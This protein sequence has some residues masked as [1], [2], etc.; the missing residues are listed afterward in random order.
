M[1]AHLFSPCFKPISNDPKADFPL[2]YCNK[3]SLDKESCNNFTTISIINDNE[4]LETIEEESLMIP[5]LPT[6]EIM[7]DIRGQIPNNYKNNESFTTASSS[8]DFDVSQ[9]NIVL[10]QLEVIS[11]P[12][13]QSIEEISWNTE[14]TPTMMDDIPAPK[15]KIHEN[16]MTE[17]K[18][19]TAT[20]DK[21]LTSVAVPTKTE[22]NNRD[23]Q[24]SQR[25]KC[26]CQKSKC[27][28]LYCECFYSGNFC[29]DCNCD[30]C[31][32]KS[33]FEAERKKASERIAAKN[34]IGYN[35]R[36]AHINEKENLPKKSQPEIRCNCTRSNCQ[37]KYCECY[38]IGGKC[39]PLCTCVNCTNAKKEEGDKTLEKNMEGKNKRRA[40]ASSNIKK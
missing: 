4:S 28:K 6:S 10:L 18:L 17:R 12:I 15:D 7:L 21:G 19:N 8:I 34:P 29:Q 23:K 20:S 5:V 22:D 25:K 31:Q 9:Q 38:K 27:L 40:K 14:C 26:N 33:E 24:S 11:F 39:G 32:N 3:L 36:I 13:E 37:K 1:Q 30:C 2:S 16:V 35:R